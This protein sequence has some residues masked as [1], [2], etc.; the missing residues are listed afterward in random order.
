MRK[1]ITLLVFSLLIVSTGM[2]GENPDIMK[3]QESSIDMLAAAVDGEVF[4]SGNKGESAVY[5]GSFEGWHSFQ[6]SSWFEDRERGVMGSTQ[7]KYRF[8]DLT[9]ISERTGK[10]IEVGFLNRVLR[11]DTEKRIVFLEQ[12]AIE[13]AT[14]EYIKEMESE[15]NQA[16]EATSANA[17]VASP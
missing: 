12:S 17:P 1:Q 10:E 9:L 7:G 6:L 2:N 8:K 13:K 16:V 3:L 4:G 14:E 5:Y 11:V 15:Q